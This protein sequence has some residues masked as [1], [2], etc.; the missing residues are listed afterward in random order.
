M[1]WRHCD[2]ESG[3]LHVVG[4]PIERTKN[5]ETPIVPMISALKNLLHRLRSE[6]AHEPTTAPV[7]IVNEAQ[8]SMD[9]AGNLEL[10]FRIRTKFSEAL[11]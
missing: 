9:R 4:D 5:G 11:W 1:E 10:D 2:F 6:R 8:K 3:K 7:M